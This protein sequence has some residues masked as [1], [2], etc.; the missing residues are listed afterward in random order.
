[1]AWT[2]HNPK[3]MTHD[4]CSL[5]CITP[6]MTSQWVKTMTHDPKSITQDVFD[7]MHDIM[8][9]TH[10]SKFM[11]LITHNPNNEEHRQIPKDPF[12]LQGLDPFQRDPGE[13]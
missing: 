1:M 4:P 6:C 9:G 12:G 13:Q 7:I 8:L 11:T 5:M 3:P 2:I 10:D